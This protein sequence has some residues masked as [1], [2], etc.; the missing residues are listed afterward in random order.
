MEGS[1]RTGAASLRVPSGLSRHRTEA[2]KQEVTIKYRESEKDGGLRTQWSLRER[3]SPARTGDLRMQWGDPGRG[4]GQRGGCCR[5][6]SLE[7]TMLKVTTA[8]QG[9]GRL[10]SEAGLL[11]TRAAEKLHNLEQIF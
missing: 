7:G 4:P 10:E 11:P 5:L 2:V 3:W 9:G 6:G 1:E 8:A